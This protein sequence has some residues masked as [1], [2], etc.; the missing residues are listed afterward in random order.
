[1]KKRWLAVAGAILVLGFGV[2]VWWQD[3]QRTAAR[4][5]AIAA[6][7]AD[8][9]AAASSRAARKKAE[10]ASSSA[11]TKAKAAAKAKAESESRAKAKAA[12]EAKAASHAKSKAAA[13]AK[14]KAKAAAAEAQAKKAAA[15]KAA[16]SAK[17]KAASAAATK[18]QATPTGTSWAAR[19]KQLK[20]Y[21][22]DVAADGTV[23]VSYTNLTP[24]AGSKA[25]ASAPARYKYETSVNGTTWTVS[26]ST[27][28]LYITAFLYHLRLTGQ[29]K[30]TSSDALNFKNMIEQS[31]NPFA[32]GIRST[33]GNTT[34]NGYLNTLG[35]TS[36]FVTG[37]AASTTSN[38]LMRLLKLLAAGSAPFS[39][40][41]MRNE[42]LSYMGVQIYRSGIPAGVASV[43]P[44]ATVQD[45]VGF[46]NDQNNDAGLVTLPTGQRYLLVIMTRGHGQ[47][48]LDFSRIKA[49]AAQVESI[50]YE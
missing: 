49:I 15:Q 13:A 27:Y 19:Q 3:T 42:L 8:Q 2:V 18:S 21:L 5:A 33:Y 22:T 24:V 6:E 39:D 34:I 23:S 26:A 41:T 40:A 20:A 28:K 44:D 9:Q 30:W 11:A 45:K 29:R 16:A 7:K 35:I 10:A 17:A 32:E 47:E 36:P 46:L 4:P 48:T 50:M 1:M 31:L 14:A 25:A 37:Q 12:S 38:D 43:T